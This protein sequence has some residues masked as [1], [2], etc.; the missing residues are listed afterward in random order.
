MG[1][2]YD[3]RDFFQK[4]LNFERAY[5]GLSLVSMHYSKIKSKITCIVMNFKCES[6]LIMQASPYLIT[7]GSRGIGQALSWQLAAQGEHV[8]IVGRHPETLEATCL[9]Y[10]NNITSIVADISQEE[11][12][13][14]VFIAL[15]NI[16][17]LKG[18]IHNAATVQPIMP[19][20]HVSL[21]EWRKIQQLNVEAPL[22]LTQQCLP[23]LKNSK[24]LF[25]SSKVAHVAQPCLGP[26]CVSKAG[27]SMLYQCFN[28]DFH[29]LGVYDSSVMPGI[30]KTDMFS[31]IAANPLFPEENRRFYQSVI[32][33]NEWI[34]PEVVACFI[35]W[36]L[37]SVEN[38][39]FASK[40]WDIYDESHHID[41]VK[42][43][44]KPKSP[45]F[46]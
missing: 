31:E 25:I 30:V 10:P 3:E 7:G 14:K 34:E 38:S 33:K 41:W 40:E 23:Q 35:E 39:V 37:C 24:V 26:Y 20:T 2:R 8:I 29:S 36:L 45:G 19:L 11:G 6:K 1:T 46:A 15:E 43:F 5:Y 17:H 4:P 9:R 27:V 12:R 32:E 22:F 18:L 13:K 44:P 16:L 28:I 42:S 21:E